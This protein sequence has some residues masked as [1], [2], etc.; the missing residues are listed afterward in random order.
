MKTGI[1]KK[2]RQWRCSHKCDLSD[3]HTIRDGI[4]DQHGMVLTERIVGCRCWKC[5]KMLTAS[6]GL[7]LDC[8][9]EK[10]P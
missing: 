10:K 9:W 3:L 1:F 4:V 5:G 8:Q 6:Y 7:E 2:L